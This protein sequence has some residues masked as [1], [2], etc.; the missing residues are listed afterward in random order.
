MKI[1]VNFNSSRLYGEDN[2][3]SGLKSKIRSVF[4]KKNRKVFE[5][6]RGVNRSVVI[7]SGPS[8]PTLS[9]DDA[10]EVSEQQKMQ[11]YLNIDKNSR[12][13]DVVWN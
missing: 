6:D 9:Y 4:G 2:K 8:F 13:T 10:R 7:E 3:E 1:V 12:P 5:A 11:Y